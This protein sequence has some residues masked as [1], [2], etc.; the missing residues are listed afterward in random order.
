[1]REKMIFEWEDGNVKE[2]LRKGDDFEL[3][4]KLELL[5]GMK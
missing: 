2:R 5:G 3:S 1:M 4:E